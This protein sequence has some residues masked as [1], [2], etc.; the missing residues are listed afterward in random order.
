[1]AVVSLRK[2]SNAD[3]HQRLERMGIRSV[4]LPLGVVSKSLRL[5]YV[6]WTLNCLIRQ[7]ITWWRY[8]L[9]ERHFSPDVVVLTSLR[10]AILLW[11]LVDRRHTLLYLHSAFQRTAWTRRLCR[12]LDRR[13]TG[14]IAVSD[15]IAG[16]AISVGLPPKKTAVVKNG[17]LDETGQR[18]TKPPADEPR[19]PQAIGIVGQIGAWK[20]HEDLVQAAE[21]LMREGGDFRVRIFGSGDSGYTEQLKSEIRRRG[22]NERFEWMGFVRDVKSLYRAIDI[23]VVPSRSEEPFGLVAV[24]AGAAGLPVV[25]TQCGG[26]PE[27]V[28]DGKS[29]FL[30][31]PRSPKALAHRLGQLLTDAALCRR[32]GEHA[33][34]RVWSLFTRAQMATAFEQACQQLIKCAEPHLSAVR[35]SNGPMQPSP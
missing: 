20:G 1:M 2:W 14:Y 15:Y 18:A 9:L 4:E 7:P 17:P 13:M 21:L 22:L 19:K 10:Q 16:N 8:T 3:F 27:I 32:M 29:G 6:I 35:I 34:A 12:W 24:E 11:P 5:K 26:L 33:C 30:V 25:A 31:P 28:V 23:C